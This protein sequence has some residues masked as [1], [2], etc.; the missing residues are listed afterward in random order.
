MAIIRVPLQRP[1][2]PSDEA[3]ETLR[4]TSATPVHAMVRGSAW[5]ALTKRRPRYT[6]EV[7]WNLS[8]ILDRSPRLRDEVHSTRGVLA[9]PWARRWAARVHYQASNTVTSASEIGADPP[10]IVLRVLDAGLAV[11]DEVHWRLADRTLPMGVSVRGRPIG[12]DDAENAAG[13]TWPVL[14]VDTGS[15]FEI[16]TGLALPHRP[17]LLLADPDALNYFEIETTAASFHKLEVQEV[18]EREISQ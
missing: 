18:P 12:R 8:T 3:L 5:A 11:I 13:I 16:D 17:R 14:S 10:V 9:S 4:I 7:P 1:D 6:F 2:L 15:S